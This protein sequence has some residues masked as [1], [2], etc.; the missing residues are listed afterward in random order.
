MLIYLFAYAVCVHVRIKESAKVFLLLRS[1]YLT[2]FWKA[3]L[4]SKINEHLLGRVHI[5]LE[6]GLISPRDKIIK[7]LTMIIFRTL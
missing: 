2:G 5:Y 1:F 3:A 7:H 6:E 4:L